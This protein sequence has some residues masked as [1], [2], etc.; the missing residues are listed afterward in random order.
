MVREEESVEISPLAYL[1]A[2]PAVR[3]LLTSPAFSQRRSV[4][5][6]IPITFAAWL[7]LN[8][9]CTAAGVDV[10]EVTG[11]GEGIAPGLMARISS[12][13]IG[14]FSLF[15]FIQRYIVRRDTPRSFEA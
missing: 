2:P 13:D 11:R 6:D 1:R 14:R 10:F 4:R 8:G 9:C 3:R 7:T 5:G 15:S 12:A